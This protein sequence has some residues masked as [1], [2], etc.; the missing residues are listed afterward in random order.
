MT[1][2]LRIRLVAFAAAFVTTLALAEGV[3]FL[4]FANGGSPQLVQ[5]LSASGA[6]V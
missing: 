3:S 6:A 1:T 2:P 4:A 5:A